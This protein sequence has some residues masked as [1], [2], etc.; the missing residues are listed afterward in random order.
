MKKIKRILC[1]LLVI[2]TVLSLCS[3][4]SEKMYNAN[5]T[6]VF[7]TFVQ[8]CTYSQSRKEFDALAGEVVEILTQYHRLYD[9]YNDYDGINNIKTI[10]DNAGV[11]PVKVDKKI[12]DLLKFCKDAYY[13]TDGNVNVA[14]GSVLSLWHDARQS[15]QTTAYPEIPD[16]DD[17]RA[18]SLHTDIECIVIDED[19]N[20]VYITDPQTSLDVG[21]VAKGYAT[22]RAYE[23]IINKGFDSGFLSVGGNVKVLGARD[24]GKSTGWNVGI[25]NPDTQYADSPLAV[26]CA[27]KGALATSGDYQ[28]YFVVDGVKYHHI[29]DKDTLMPS[30]GMR[31]V[32]IWCDDSGMADVLSTYFFTIS[33]EDAL[34]FIEKHPGLEIKAYWIFEDGSIQYTAD[35]AAYLQE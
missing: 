9:I 33:Y 26:V 14:M 34:G 30:V 21:A 19:N 10:N 28:R 29:I 1:L 12:I 5:Y 7:D 24:D 13:L 3:C 18:A 22:E 35:L 32:S 27:D 20:T 23:Y 8:I 11:A 16:M 4:S 6:G 2:F 17:L 15:M 25:Q 31:G